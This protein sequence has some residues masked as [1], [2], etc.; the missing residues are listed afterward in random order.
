MMDEAQQLKDAFAIVQALDIE[1]VERRI[2]WLEEAL[3]VYKMLRAVKVIHDRK[4]EGLRTVFDKP[5]P[6]LEPEQSSPTSVPDT[7]RY[8]PNFVQSA[9]MMPAEIERMLGDVMKPD[10][11][12]QVGTLSKA[13]GCHCSTLHWHMVKR[14][15]TYHRNENGSWIKLNGDRQPTQT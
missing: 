11:E 3:A 12:Y 5:S 4:P 7:S 14:A 8:T 13:T 9:P 15:Q 2:A 6:S 1:E 10:R